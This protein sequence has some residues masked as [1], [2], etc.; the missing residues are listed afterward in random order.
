MVHELSQSSPSNRKGMDWAGRTASI[1][2]WTCNSPRG[3]EILISYSS[4]PVPGVLRGIWYEILG[5]GLC[6]W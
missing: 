5:V 4:L 1:F 2:C 3:H 6:W